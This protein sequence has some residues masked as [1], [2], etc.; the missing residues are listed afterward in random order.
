MPET[1][2]TAVPYQPNPAQEA[3]AAGLRRFNRLF[4]YIPV[5]VA[6]LIVA[7][8]VGL[9]LWQALSPDQA[10]GRQA[11]MRQLISALTDIIIIFTI[12]PLMLLCA[13]VPSLTVGLFFYRR[14]KNSQNPREY[15]RLQ[16]LFWRIEN[17]LDK[18]QHKI[19]EI[20]P[21]LTRPLIQANARFSY[22]EKLI[23]QLRNLFNRS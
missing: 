3:R 17:I 20:S 2:D 12:L 15:G 4:V 18:I 6:G 14:Q 8:L 7:G 1:S 16:I 11:D 23:Q 13:I 22:L 9:M 5:A 19:N 21:R 10:D